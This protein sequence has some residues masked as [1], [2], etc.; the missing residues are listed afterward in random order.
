MMTDTIHYSIS[1]LIIGFPMYF[2]AI[3]LW[4]K[5]FREDEKKIESKLTKW[6]TYLVLLFSSV[7][8]VGDLIYMVYNFL[9]GEI[10]IRFFLK[11]LTVLVVAGMV[12]G[13]YYF[14][15][16]KIQYKKDIPRSLFSN[17]GYAMIAIVVV[18]IILGFVATGSPATER[19]RAFDETRAKDL[20][21]I[22]SCIES[23]ANKF[24]K[25]PT[26]LK[27]FTQTNMPYCT[28]KR[29]PETKEPYEYRVITQLSPVSFDSEEGEFELCAVFS[30]DSGDDID[31]ERMYGSY[32]SKWHEHNAGRSCDTEIVRVRNK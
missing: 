29:D 18:G 20:S 17:F 32:N 31:A 30:L 6:V 24:E 15:R 12:F 19:K 22:A 7:S 23:Y 13:F 21:Q 27:D 11:A 5:R 4:F 28:V 2:F 1:A 16:K 25:L 9:E 3:K 10:S 26:S 14:E 8:I